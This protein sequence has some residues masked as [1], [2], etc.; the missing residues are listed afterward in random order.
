MLCKLVK[1]NKYWKILL[2]VGIL[3]LFFGVISYKTIS[4]DAHN[5]AMLKGMTAGLGGAFTAIAGIKLLQN[6][7]SPAEKLKAKEIEAKDERNIQI[8]RISYSISN[9]VAVILFAVMAFLFIG[10]NYII[11]AFISIGAMYIQVI[12]FFIANK[13]YNK[14]I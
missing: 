12:A 2:L 10:L 14:K 1:S 13:Y 3:P 9:T 5:I 8:L 11:P 7:M 6:K 4:S